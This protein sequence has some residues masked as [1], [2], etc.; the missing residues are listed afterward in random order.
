MFLRRCLRKKNGKQHT[1]W[2]LVVRLSGV[3]LERIR[4]FGDMWLTWAAELA[5]CRRSPETSRRGTSRRPC[6]P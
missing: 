1:Y 6:P 3:R 5:S 2:A 4:D